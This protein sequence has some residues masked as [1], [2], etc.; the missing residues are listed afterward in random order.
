M[1]VVTAAMVAAETHLQLHEA[2][3]RAEHR[4]LLV[5]CSLLDGSHTA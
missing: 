2:R 5:Y 4:I 3:V 1:V